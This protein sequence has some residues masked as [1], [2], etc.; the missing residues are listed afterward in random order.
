MAVASP[1]VNVC[2]L[3]HRGGYCRGCLRT[4]EEI[5][6]WR[7]LTDHQCNRILYD[8][9]RRRARLDRSKSDRAVEGLA[10]AEQ[11]NAL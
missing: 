8:L 10:T 7:K 2:R 1:C 4:A 9:K 11:G 3:D 6:R 5:R